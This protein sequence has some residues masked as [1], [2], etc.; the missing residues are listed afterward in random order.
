MRKKHVW[1]SAVLVGLSVWVGLVVWL[2]VAI[3]RR[4]GQDYVRSADVIIVLGAGIRED[5]TANLA[6]TRRSL[7]AAQRYREGY[8]DAILCSGGIAP[9]RPRSEAEA[10]RDVLMGAGVPEEAI[11]L[12]MAS[13]S[14]EE[15]ALYS[16]PI[17]KEQGW[18]DAVLV[19]DS[20]HMLRAEWL[21]EGLGL[22]VAGSPVPREQVPTGLYRQSFLRE[23]AAFHWHIFKTMLGLPL[24]HFP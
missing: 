3:E 5:G 24:T 7:W 16:A 15:N 13:R 17:M 18:A 1:L 9:D 12:E 23:I 10:C 6:L 11:V 8:A 22:V 2:M 20:Y 21:F 19:T 4:G 14:T